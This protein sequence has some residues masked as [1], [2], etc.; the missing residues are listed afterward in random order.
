VKSQT[1]R[2]VRPETMR[3]TSWGWSRLV[4]ASGPGYSHGSELVKSVEPPWNVL[5]AGTRRP[6]TSSNNWTLKGK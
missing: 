6:L 5:R 3:M 4:R 1:C 2:L